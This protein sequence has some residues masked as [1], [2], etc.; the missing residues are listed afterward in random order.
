MNHISNTF[1]DDPID[2]DINIDH[3]VRINENSNVVD[4]I[5]HVNV[6]NDDIDEDIEHVFDANIDDDA[7]VND[8]TDYNVDIFDPRNWDGLDSQMIDILVVKG[9]KRD[10]SIIKGAKDKMGRQFSSSFYTRVLPNGEKIDREA[11]LE[12]AD[13]DK[14]SLI[15]SEAKSLANNELGDF[16]F[17]VA[18]II[19][20]DL[21]YAV[22]LVSKK[23]QSKDMFVCD[24]IESLKHLTSF[25]KNYR[26]NGFM[27]A[28]EI[29]KKLAIDLEID[30]TFPQK[31][32]IKRNKQ[33][34]DT[35]HDKSPQSLQEAFRINFFNCIIDQ[36]IVS[37]DTRFEQYENIF[38]FLFTSDI[39]H[40]LDD[41]YLKSCCIRLEEALKNGE[42]YD[43]CGYDLYVE[44]KL[45][46]EYLPSEKLGALDTLKRLKRVDC[47]PNAVIAYR[48]LLTIPVT[49]ASAERSFSKL[50][51]LKTYLRSSMSQERL[52][53][54]ALIAIE[55]EVLDKDAYEDLIDEFASKN[56]R[57]KKIFK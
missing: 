12:V 38:G 56:A 5:E 46:Q 26:I 24:A 16:E 47:F 44:L 33:F 35:L 23:L 4:D 57:R 11:L 42:K 54:L 30:P 14:D 39:L 37:L 51:L 7:F 9:P 29:A 28:V 43:I 52:N 32:Q 13:S 41:S 18:I 49:V 6:V 40:S 55:N 15:K 45:V 27:N 22:N 1:V 8:N 48:I 3:N 36:E 21:L 50:K 17:I 10:L 25:F 31:R 2:N 20:Y 34:D 53:G 19:W